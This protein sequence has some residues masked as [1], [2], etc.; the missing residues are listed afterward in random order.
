MEGSVNIKSAAEIAIM[1]EAGRINAEAL[2]AVKAAIAPGVTTAELN[3]VAEAVHR[4]YGVYSP[5]KNYPGPYPFPAS[6]CA[7]VNEE[8]VHGIPDKRKLKEGD[9]VSIDCGT[10]FEGFV[11][12][13]AFTAGVG[14]ISAQAQRLIE[15]TK[16]ALDAAI[17]QMV[18]GNHLGDIGA[19]VEG[20]VL[21]HG[22]HATHLYTG[23]GVGREMHE[24]PLVPNYGQPGQG[25]LLREGMTL[26][27]EPMVLVGTRYTRE[28]KNQWTVISR[29]RSLTAH[30]EHTVAIT[31]NGPEILTRL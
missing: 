16:Q 7:S 14:V 17:A 13:S 21:K 31:A 15:I 24:S 28:L 18:P 12:D 26:A 1:R 19:A 30:Q 8:L 9:I 3:E 4:K 22:L 27:I 23:H 25:M 6:I 11:G 5:F 20:L 29:D 10:V 2:E